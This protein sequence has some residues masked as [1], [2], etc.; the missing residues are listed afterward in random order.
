MAARSGLVAATL[1]V[2][3]GL[4]AGG[5]RADNPWLGDGAVESET[6]RLIREAGAESLFVS[7]SQ[8]SLLGARHTKSGLLC[9]FSPGDRANRILVF[10]K[11]EPRLPRGDDVGCTTRVNGVY[12]SLYAAR[13]GDRGGVDGA[14]KSAVDGLITASPG[15]QVYQGDH[16]ENAEVDVDGR[17]LPLAEHRTARFVIEHEGRKLF[18][19]VS[20]AVVDGWDIKQRVS[21]PIE[22]AVALDVEAEAMMTLVLVDFAMNA[23]GA[24][25]VAQAGER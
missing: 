17:R 21:G 14:L 7:E 13:L 12:Q 24:A 22:D 16:A 9:T 20:V 25:P 10:D 23:K 8:G 18:T 5:A 3:L 1:A 4:F 15:A 6:E 19:R 11:A 2:C